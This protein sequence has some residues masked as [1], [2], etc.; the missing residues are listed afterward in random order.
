MEVQF[1]P[2]VQARL[3]QRATQE[4]MNPDEVVRDVVARYF[5]EEDRFVEAVTRGEAALERGEL[6]VSSLLCKRLQINSTWFSA[7][8]SYKAPWGRVGSSVKVERSE[9]ARA[10]LTGL[11]T[12]PYLRSG[13]R[14]GLC[15]W[16]RNSP[17]PE[18]R[19]AVQRVLPV[20]N[21]LP[22]LG[23]IAQRQIEQFARRLFVGKRAACLD[24]LA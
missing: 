20:L 7:S 15:A 8:P 11:L 4:G 16:Q 19:K 1:S 17:G 5:K 3:A 18:D 14:S 10:A 22:L 21:R 2:D 6:V 9:P 24:H 12:L 23:D 13:G